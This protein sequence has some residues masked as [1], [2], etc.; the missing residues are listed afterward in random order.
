MG[1]I[2]ANYESGYN[3]QET[4]GDDSGYEVQPSLA[5]ETPVGNTEEAV[6]YYNGAGTCTVR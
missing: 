2:N 1:A 5:F 6:T 4:G 3:A